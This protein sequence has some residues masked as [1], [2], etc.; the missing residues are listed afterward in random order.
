MKTLLQKV[1]ESVLRMRAERLA[2]KK[3]LDM[4]K[5]RKSG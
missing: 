3:N 1:R 5:K 2:R 4:L